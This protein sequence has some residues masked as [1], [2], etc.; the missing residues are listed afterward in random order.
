MASRREILE[1]CRKG[2]EVKGIQSEKPNSHITTRTVE[3]ILDATRKKAGIPE[4]VTVHTLRH[5]FAT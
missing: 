1:Q 4:H 5:S 3:K 2:I